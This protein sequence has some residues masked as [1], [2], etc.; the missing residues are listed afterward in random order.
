MR[1]LSTL[2][3]AALVF[4]GCRTE[5]TADPNR[6]KDA[7]AAPAATQG[8]D[9]RPLSPPANES[10]RQEAQAFA[11]FWPDFRQALLAQ[12]VDR[13]TAATRFPLEIR[14]ERDS[15]PARRRDRG[16]LGDV[17]RQALD[18]DSGMRAEP[19]SVRQFLQRTPEPAAGS[20][21]ADGSAARV[22]DFVFERV[23]GHWQLVRVYLREPM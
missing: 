11:A 23:E 13:V 9:A 6:R 22:G 4:A 7:A 15:D 8:A 12:D 20:V 14:G 10:A 21:E 5:Q 18:Q 3:L 16:Q 19:E 2:C 1:Y 17:L